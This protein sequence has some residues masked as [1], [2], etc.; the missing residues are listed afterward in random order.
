MMERA[1]KAPGRGWYFALDRLMKQ[2][3]NNQTPAT[4]ALSLLYALDVQLVRIADEGIEHRWQRHLDMQSRTFDWVGEMRDNGVGIDF[5]AQEGHRSPTVTTV[6]MP[7]DAGSPAVVA[8]MRDRGWVIGG[9][10]GSLK[11]S[12]F[13]IGHMGDHTVD[14]LDL[15]LDELRDVL[16]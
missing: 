3:V 14:E 4:P 10:Y 2:L 7:G 13:R 1:S 8:E 9:G 12:T 6:R 16:R 11:E 15:L 5:F